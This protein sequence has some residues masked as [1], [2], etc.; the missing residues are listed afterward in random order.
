MALGAGVTD[1]SYYAFLKKVV[2]TLLKEYVATG[3]TSVHQ[4]KSILYYGL[5]YWESVYSW[6]IS[7]HIPA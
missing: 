5:S 6:N 1:Y 4:V 3:V 7:F 2:S